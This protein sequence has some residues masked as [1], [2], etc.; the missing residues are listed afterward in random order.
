MTSGAQGSPRTDSIHKENE[1]GFI[2]L[3]CE[4]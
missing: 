3:S 1:G 4:Q 2:K